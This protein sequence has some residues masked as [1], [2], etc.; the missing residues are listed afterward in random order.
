MYHVPCIGRH[1]RGEWNIYQSNSREDHVARTEQ[2][3]TKIE[4]K[5]K[6]NS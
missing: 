3:E 2:K 4:T 6:T 5:T 1:N